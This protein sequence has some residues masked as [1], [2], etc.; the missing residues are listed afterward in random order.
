MAQNV[1]QL[2]SEETL[3][4]AAEFLRVLGHPTRLRSVEMLLSGR[5]CVSELAEACGVPQNVASEHLRLMQHCGLLRSEKKGRQ[6]FYRVADPKLG[7][8]LEC[9]RSCYEKKRKKRA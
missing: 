8:F 1:T 9:I 4:D 7:S 3:H 5:Y 6:T 2:M